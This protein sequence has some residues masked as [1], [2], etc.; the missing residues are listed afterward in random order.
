MNRAETTKR[1]KRALKERTGRT[2]SV[3]GGRGT[4][5]GW[6]KI[7]SPKGRRVN[8]AISPKYADN[9]HIYPAPPDFLLDVAP[10]EG[11]IGWYMSKED[12]AIL[13]EALGLLNVSYQHIS[14]SPEEWDWYLDRAENGPPP[15]TEPESPPDFDQTEWVVKNSEPVIIE[16]VSVA[17]TDSL[18]IR[19]DVRWPTLNKMSHLKEYTEQLHSGD[20]TDSQTKVVK[21]A[22]LT[23]EDYDAFVD[24]NLLEDQ[25]WLAEE[26]GAAVDWDDSEVE[27]YGEIWN[28]PEELIERFRKESYILSVL[29]VADGRTDLFVN[30]EGYNYA[31]YVGLI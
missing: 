25:D 26:G 4:G 28:W 19:R 21:I 3:T 20:Y 15:P 29:V 14:I 5:W 2:W 13:Q 10:D 1:I 8:H 27:N 23:P 6:L 12:R 17:D 30:P 11:E 9:P 31:R 24:G 16:P 7:T 18:N 22:R